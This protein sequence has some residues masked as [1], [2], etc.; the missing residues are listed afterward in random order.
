MKINRAYKVELNPNNKQSTL[1][2]KSAGVA[3]FAYNWG[4]NEKINLW[5]S[6]KKSLTS[7]D[8]HKILCGKKKIEFPWMYEVSKMAP[9]EAL[10]DLDTAFKNFF[11][12]IKKGQKVGFPKFKSK[13]KSKQKFSISYGFYVSNTEVKIPKVGRI[14]LKEKSYI[15]TKDVKINSMTVSKD[16]DRWFISVQ[17]EQNAPE[18][19]NQIESVLGIDVGIKTLATC[20]NG[21]VFENNKY[22][23]KSKKKLAHAQK[24]LARKKFDKETKRSSNNRNKGKLKVQKI[25]RRIRNQRIDALHKMTSIL[26]K[27]KPR[28]IVLEDLNVSGMMKNHKLAGAIGDASFN[29]IKRQLTYKT[30]WY[31]GSIVDVDRFFPSSKMCS[32][33]GSLKEDI[34]L[35]DRIYICDCGNIMDRDLNA[36]INLEKY[37]LNNLNNTDSLSG[38]KACGESVR[39]VQVCLIEEAVSVKQ[40]ENIKSNLC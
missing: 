32:V 21:E 7:I 33:C 19:N 31:G 38:I 30:S 8:Q 37:G 28:Y 26:A 40:E 4:L 25:Y 1:L 13:H 14:R 18:P 29:E 9:Q 15:P 35:G 22:L 12:G 24:K 20:S 5:K 10:R 3:R 36:S 27:T 34:T 23:K 39:P 2:E 16:A 17:V 11:R 6:E